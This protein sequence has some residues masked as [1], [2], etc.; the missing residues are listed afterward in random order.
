MK[1]SLMRLIK[2]AFFKATSGCRK[3]VPVA[4]LTEFVLVKQPSTDED[5]VTNRNRA[6][7]TI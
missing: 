3:K 6:T 5:T 2:G 1:S 7:T 4:K